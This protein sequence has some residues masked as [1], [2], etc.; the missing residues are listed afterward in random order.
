MD[1]MEVAVS[2]ENTCKERVVCIYLLYG[3]VAVC[4]HQVVYGINDIG[5]TCSGLLLGLSLCSPLLCHL[6][7][8]SAKATSLPIRAV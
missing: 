2:C 4:V 7:H 5:N 8:N 3:F 6:L 1:M